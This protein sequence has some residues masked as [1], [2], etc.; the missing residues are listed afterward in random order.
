MKYNN[1]SWKNVICN[2]QSEKIFRRV[3]FNIQGV[4]YGEGGFRSSITKNLYTFWH[5]PRCHSLW[6]VTTFIFLGK[7]LES[8]SMN[9]S[10]NIVRGDH[11]DRENSWKLTTF[12]RKINV[13]KQNVGTKTNKKG[14]LFLVVIIKNFPL[15][16]SEIHQKSSIKFG[17]FC[18][19]IVEHHKVILIFWMRIFY[20]PEPTF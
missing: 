14:V 13:F 6:F 8:E 19:L 1:F 18:E 12:F 15:I 5:F 16:A 11:Y 10:L 9:F 17:G 3:F 20:R 4:R 7:F 2:F